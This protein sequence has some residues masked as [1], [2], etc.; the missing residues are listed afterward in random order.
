M[1]SYQEV[2]KEIMNDSYVSYKE[3]MVNKWDYGAKQCDNCKQW[4]LDACEMATSGGVNG[5]DSICEHCFDNV[6]N[7]LCDEVRRIVAEEQ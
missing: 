2:L 7:E 4:T 6:K 3:A 1:T 5:E